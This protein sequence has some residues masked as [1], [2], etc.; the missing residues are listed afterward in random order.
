[1]KKIVL[2]SNNAGKLQEFEHLFSR[3]SMTVIAQA[4]LGVDDIEETGKTFIENAILKA[5]HASAVTG[6]PAIA[7]DSGLVIPAL[8]GEP[9]IYS[10]RYNGQHGDA[11]GCIDKVLR[12]MQNIAVTQRQAAFHCCLVFMRHEY[13]PV[14]V[15]SEADWQGE[16]LF[17]RQGENGFGYDHIFY[18]PEYQS[19]A[20]ELEPGLKARICHRGLAAAKLLIE[21]EKLI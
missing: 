18:V 16:I 13:D 1:M 8:N 9:G 4:Q 3:F 7:D 14:P 11:Q 12:N 19:S 6:L 10:A 15:I 21:L 17:A 20:A 5:R 2:A